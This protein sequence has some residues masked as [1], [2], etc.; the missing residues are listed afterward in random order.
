MPD[1]KYNRK[2]DRP[3]S[4][5]LE[6]TNDLPSNPHED[7][8]ESPFSA[9]SI[10][11]SVDNVA[12]ASLPDLPSALDGARHI[13][14]AEQ[15]SATSLEKLRKLKYKLSRALSNNEGNN[16]YPQNEENETSPLVLSSPVGGETGNGSYQQAIPSD[17]ELL[18]SGTQLS[19]ERGS[20]PT[21]PASQ[22]ESD[23]SRTTLTRPLSPDRETPV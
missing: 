6:H 20:R 22:A 19:D 13:T 11:S 16:S 17:C 18:S 5:N 9:K 7:D 3:Q 2:P 21:S 14:I 15:I 12:L 1:S 23:Q 8:L 4:L 10:N